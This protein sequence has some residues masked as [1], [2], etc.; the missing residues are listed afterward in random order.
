MLYVSVKKIKGKTLDLV[1]TS[2]I[3]WSKLLQVSLPEPSAEE[4]SETPGISSNFSSHADI[5]FLYQRKQTFAQKPGAQLGGGGWGG[6]GGGEGGGGEASPALF[7]NSKKCPDCVHLWVKFSI[8]NVVLKLSRRKNSNILPCGAF[9]LVFVTK[10]SSQCTNSTRPP[11][12]WKIAGCKPTW[13][14]LVKRYFIIYA[15]I[16]TNLGTITLS[17]FWHSKSL[18]IIFTKWQLVWTAAGILASI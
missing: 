11:P 18:K 8:Q 14:P 1:S 12:P 2:H 10:S 6:G 17:R 3:R 4:T 15:D 7:W 5:T 13:N 9:F 16:P